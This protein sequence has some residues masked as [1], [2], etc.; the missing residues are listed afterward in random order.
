[1]TRSSASRVA[2][3]PALASLLVALVALLALGTAHA[4]GERRGF[5]YEIRK[6]P[7]TSLLFGTIHVGRPEFY[8]LPASRLSRLSR[9]DAL[10][11]E[12]DVTDV[13][14][15]ATATQKF[16]MYGQGEDGLDKRLPPDT[17]KRAEAVLARN[18]LDP[19]PMLRLK[20]WMLGSVLALFEAAQAG[21]VQGLAAE[22]YL[23][24][25]AQADNRPILEF[26]GIEQ[27]F[28]LFENAPWSTQV[29]FLDEALRALESNAARR[30]I[31]RIVQAWETADRP[32]LERLLSEMQAQTTVGAR[33]TVDT[34]LLGRHPAMVRRIETLMADGRNYLFAVGAL[35]L[36]GPAGLVEMLRARGYTVTEL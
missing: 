27:Q 9:V 6:G 24:R 21:Y 20:P 25:L 7:Q 32:A 35:H 23:T 31:N 33:F 3:W 29:A 15:A 26:E 10:V 36:V 18:G 14:R 16:A 19:R 8:P 13:A 4:Q 12:A 22:S 5:L 1:M 28:S 30:E 2:P 34:I 11:L 17:L